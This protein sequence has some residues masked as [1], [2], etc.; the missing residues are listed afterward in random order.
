MSQLPT[1][2]I[3]CADNKRSGYAIINES[4][5][6]PDIHTP[7]ADAKEPASGNDEPVVVPD[8]WQDLHW[9]KKVALAEALAG[10]AW[11]VP[12]GEKAADVAGSVIEAHLEAQAAE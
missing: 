12:E 2:K 9:K 11:N 10:D 4:D 7:F 1:I 6:N 3:E 5:F 8:D